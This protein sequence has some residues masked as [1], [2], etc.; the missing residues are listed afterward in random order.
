M[1]RILKVPA[2]YTS[3]TTAVE[4]YTEGW[5]DALSPLPVP[6]VEPIAAAPKL[7][8]AP[9]TPVA[10][11][12]TPVSP[13]ITVAP[14]VAPSPSPNL[15]NWR[16]WLKPVVGPEY[17]PTGTDLAPLIIAGKT[18]YLS[19]TGKYTVSTTCRMKTG[20][21]KIYANGADVDFI[22]T[23][24]GCAAN[25]IGL[26]AG[27][28]VDGLHITKGATFFEA[29]S[30]GW[31][32]SRCYSDDYDSVAKTGIM[33]N[34][35]MQQYGATGTLDSNWI[36][37]TGSVSTFFYDDHTATNNWYAGSIGEYAYRTEQVGGKFCKS[38]TIR[39]NVFRYTNKFGKGSVVGL[40]RGN[41]IT[42]A[43]N[44]VESSMRIGEVAAVGGTPIATPGECNDGII[45]TANH[46]FNPWN[47]AP[48]I[49]VDQGVNIQINSNHI[50]HNSADT[51]HPTVAVDAASNATSTLNVIHAPVG[52]T[53]K[54][55]MFAASSKGK[56]A[57]TGS[58]I[59]F[60]SPG[61]APKVPWLY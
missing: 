27:I 33:S 43:E 10:K 17:V 23:E 41:G 2:K 55:G 29:E 44:W 45:L 18:I 36:G 8:P 16:K 32:V 5:N 12:P 59:A 48:V 37:V 46:Y 9:A 15:A 49:C 22:A 38:A 26:A 28:V 7:A 51:V 24:S 14:A 61:V 30:V 53:Q 35:I 54:F 13:T 60:D 42:F 56:Y 58:T 1:T 50:W 52:S 31:E 3:N 40:R 34:F 21:Q 57:D 4:A 47:Q 19:P 39:G 11:P 20:I 6:A 25:I